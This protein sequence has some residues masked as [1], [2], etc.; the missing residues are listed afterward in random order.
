MSSV[1]RRD[2]K[3]K[4]VVDMGDVKTDWKNL[5]VMFE[6][7][8]VSLNEVRE[9]FGLMQV[10]V[11]NAANAMTKSFNKFGSTVRDAADA[12]AAA[13]SQL[14]R[15]QI[16][17]ARYQQFRGTFRGEL[18]DILLEKGFSKK[19]VVVMEDDE[20]VDALR[21]KMKLATLKE[22]RVAETLMED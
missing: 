21:G 20:V 17:E 14:D 16:V 6:D 19:T 4:T 11:K 8:K 12:M 9:S 5:K 10:G 1:R 7:N 18:Y 22:K 15:E 2:N 3:N 13:V